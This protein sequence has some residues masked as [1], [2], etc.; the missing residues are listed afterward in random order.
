MTH[1]LKDETRRS[2]GVIVRKTW[3]SMRFRTKSQFEKLLLAYLW[4]C[5]AGETCAS[6]FYLSIPTIADDLETDTE[7]VSQTVR[8]L[9]SEGWFEYDDKAR[10]FFFPK[11]VEYDKP[12]NPNTL[13]A[14]IKRTLELPE[15]PLLAKFYQQLKPF[16]EQF[17]K[18]L[19]EQLTK[20]L[21]V[22]SANCLPNPQPHPHPL[23]QPQDNYPAAPE[24][25]SNPVSKEAM[26]QEAVQWGV[27]VAAE[28][29]GEEVITERERAIVIVSAIWR[30]YT[31]YNITVEQFK[32]ILRHRVLPGR[33][34]IQHALN[35]VKRLGDEIGTHVSEVRK[36]DIE[37]YEKSRKPVDA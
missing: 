29:F 35:W 10:V 4:S 34:G 16:V 26:R 15:T 27:R 9:V 8:Q 33:N 20:Q 24:N 32:W 1:P 2:Y 5:P 14:F 13:K 28:R 30:A 37:E 11:Q 23:P 6:I 19:P 3:R 31:P 12:E 21:A 7:T 18:Q 25:F 17:G 36:V 22:C